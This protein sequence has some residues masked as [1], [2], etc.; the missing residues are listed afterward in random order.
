VGGDTM[1][2]DLI[3]DSGNILLQ[4]TSL[5][6]L[7]NA[8]AIQARDQGDTTFRS[9]LMVDGSDVTEV[10]NTSLAGGTRINAP[11]EDLAVVEYGGGDKKIWHEGHF[12][13]AP[14]FTN[15]Y[16][17]E[18]QA[19]DF[20]GTGAKFTLAHEIGAKPD[21]WLAVLVCID[22]QEAY[23][24]GDEIPVMFGLVAGAAGAITVAVN[25][26]NFEWYLS[27]TNP[28]IL[29]SNGTSINIDDEHWELVFRAWY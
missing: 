7:L 10:G 23:V 21:L 24:V 27:D 26:T 11:S 6:M 25:A 2:G 20:T 22:A 3:M 8:K 4:G 1:T 12:A 28:N 18:N 17:S 9:I 19:F 5:L 15:F 16:E 13:T 29:K 14:S